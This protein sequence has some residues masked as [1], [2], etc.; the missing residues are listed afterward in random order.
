[1]EGASLDENHFLLQHK[2]QKLL[3]RYRELRSIVNINGIKGIPS[4][5]MEAYTR[6]ERLEAFLTQPFCVAESLTGQKGQSVKLEDT[7][8]DVQRIIDGEVDTK[9]VSSLTFIGNL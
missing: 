6:G 8:K 1:M 9:E 2:A 3:R 5:E 7:L 4:S